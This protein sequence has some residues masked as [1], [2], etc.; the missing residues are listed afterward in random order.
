VA[1]DDSSRNLCTSNVRSPSGDRQVTGFDREIAATHARCVRSAGVRNLPLAHESP[2][3]VRAVA[4]F[5]RRS[6]ERENFIVTLEECALEL[7][8][9]SLPRRRRAVSGCP[10]P[11]VVRSVSPLCGKI[12]YCG[13]HDSCVASFLVEE[14][15][16]AP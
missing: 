3:V 13:T 1:V 8:R 14:E 4:A 16:E 7:C 6:G 12:V 2:K 15:K 11:K 10:L 5:L 9:R